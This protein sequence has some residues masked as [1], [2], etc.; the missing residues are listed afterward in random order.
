MTR[1][2][3]SD[4]MTQNPVCAKDNINLLNAAKKMIRRRVGSL[5]LLNKKDIVGIITQRDILWALVKKSKKDL[6]KIKA[7]DISP[8]R[9]ATIRPTA[10]L[11]EVIEK[12]NK[13][14]FERLPVAQ[15]GK[16][17]GM[18]TVKDILN[19]HPEV[20]PELEEFSKI[21]EEARKIRRQK[22]AKEKGFVQGI[23]EECGERDYLYRVNGMLICESC[24][25]SM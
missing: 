21:R 3:V 4:A 14:K 1:L 18:I 6:S 10:S 5:I 17:I 11:K 24:K 7:I 22:K 19:F 20:Y 15:K 9:V 23:C 16:I 2:L 13:F 25:N 12:M 8:K